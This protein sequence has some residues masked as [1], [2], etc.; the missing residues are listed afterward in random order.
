[1]VLEPFDELKAK[2]QI[3]NTN[4]IQPHKSVDLNPNLHP[5]RRLVWLSGL[6]LIVSE[7]SF[8]QPKMSFSRLE[9]DN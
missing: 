4:L 5:L 3:G 7:I 9:L 1:M 6:L 2:D 8:K